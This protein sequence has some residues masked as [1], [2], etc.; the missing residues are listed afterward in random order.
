MSSPSLSNNTVV[1]IVASNGFQPIE[2]RL[3]KKI[4][5]E[6]GINVLTASNKPGGA[7]ASDGT[8]APVDL[9]LE[10]LDVKKYDG[11]FFIGG[12]GAME[13]L[14]NSLSYRIANEAK[15]NSVAY[16]AI[17]VAPRILAKALAL[18]GLRATGWNDDLALETILRGNKAIYDPKGIVTDELVVTA[19][20]P[21]TAQDFAEGIIR[22]LTKRKYG[23]KQEE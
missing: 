15:N 4:L 12:P 11:V 14:D 16:G 20:G 6:Y 10:N 13:H 23:Y 21:E 7:I 5:E 17:C 3:P 2:Y 9:I 8:T 19:T 1:F 18:E 22:V